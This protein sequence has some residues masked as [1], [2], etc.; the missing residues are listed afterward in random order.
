M[1]PRSTSS[2]A[3]LEL[4]PTGYLQS[5]N[6][7]LYN[8]ANG[9][10][11]ACI[12][13]LVFSTV[14]GFGFI[15]LGALASG[16]GQ[17][18]H[19]NSVALELIPLA[20]NIVVLIITE[21]LGYIHA[22][23]LRWALFYEGKLEFNTNLR[24]LTFSRRNVSNGWAANVIFFVTLAVCYG[25]S[26][27]ILV[28]N[29]YK[30][31]LND[32]GD[33]NETSHFVSISQATPI[34]LGVA[35]LVQG[36]LATWCLQ[37]SKIPTWSSHPLTTLAAATHQGGIIH[38]NGRSMMSAR[39]RSLPPTAMAPVSRQESPYAV[40][41]RVFHVLVVTSAVLLILI[42]WTAIIIPVGR[43]TSPG[44]S[45]SFIPT[46]AVDYGSNAGDFLPSMTQTV[47]LLF[48]SKHLDPGV[49]NY[50]P[51]SN[52]LGILAFCVMIQSCLTVGLHCAELQV[53]MQR[54]ES[55]WRT[56]S[57]PEGSK[58]ESTYNSVTQPLMFVPNAML[59]IFKPVVHW[60]FGSA[61]QVDYAKGVLMR[62]PHIT[63]LTILWLVF[64]G[65]VAFLS[66]RR[67]KGPLP[68]TYGHLQTMA[69]LADEVGAV[70][71]FGDKGVADASMMAEGEEND[72]LDG[73]GNSELRHAGTSAEPLPPVQ[74]GSLY[75]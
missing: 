26:P 8:R 39:M 48:F 30:F 60:F 17:V 36:A 57:S 53:I 32:G 31:Y 24:L 44:G 33:W 25:A 5:N 54:D 13:G 42:I 7:S 9:A 37:T 58:S 18:Y 4:Q 73:M 20:I 50:V 61:L 75:I 40:A 72:Q 14:I 11:K 12:A 41:P 29:T 6:L 45:W 63:Y 71:F 68:V 62:V 2:Y 43:H 49:P 52:I 47:F 51:E 23:S 46:S 22:T 16:R 59:L 55:I 65:F 1:K 56:L 10:R 28:R 67:P 3:P 34:A 66:F 35:I 19:L 27:M 64:V 70:M 74:I 21:S 69:D 38:R 15:V